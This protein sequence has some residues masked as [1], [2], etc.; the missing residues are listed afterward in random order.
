[1]KISFKLL[2]VLLFFTAGTVAQ[3]IRDSAGHG[4][5]LLQTKENENLNDI[6]GSP[7]LSDGFKS[8]IV[9]VEGK[10][11]LNVFLRYDVRN[12]NF[13]IKT[14]FNSSEIYILPL[15]HKGR[16]HLGTD[17]FLY[18]QISYDGNII[19]GYFIEHF[20]GEDV[21]F[22]EKPVIDFTPAQSARTGYDEA[23]PAKIEVETEFYLVF[24][25][26][27]VEN[28]KMR[29][30]DIRKIFRSKADRDFL[31]DHDIDNAKDLVEFLKFHNS[32]E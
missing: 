29:N 25:D 32:K 5:M 23:E 24:E 12:E 14:D 31:S 7:Y 9:V 15:T 3:N 8:G 18:D 28:P 20:D 17:T 4:L 21:R 22:L 19:R 26:G 11:P 1:M 10:E 27:K 30:R 2:I 13:E 6:H 16:Y